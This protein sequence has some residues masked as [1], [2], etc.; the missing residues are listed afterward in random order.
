MID[1]TPKLGLSPR[2]LAE[3]MALRKTMTVAEKLNLTKKKLPQGR[4]VFGADTVVS[5][6]GSIFGKPVDREDAGRMLACL[7]GR[8]HEVVTA[9]ALYNGKK[10]KADCRHVSSLVRFSTLSKAE[11]EWYLDSGEWQDV[12]GAYRI[13]G[14]AGCFI[15]GI[16]GSPSAVVGLS[17]HGFYAML[18]DNGYPFGAVQ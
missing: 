15:E 4:W 9:M 18:R 17:L 3:D 14:M 10:G 6:D 8:E 12:A 1:E 5:V 13:Q 2:Q 7:S 11:I 16:Q